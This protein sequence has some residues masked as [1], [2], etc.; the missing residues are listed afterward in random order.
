MFSKHFPYFFI[1]SWNGVYN[2]VKVLIDVLNDGSEIYIIP[3][4]QI[5]Q[6]FIC[7][8]FGQFL[9]FFPSMSVAPIILIVCALGTFS[10]YLPLSSISLSS[11]KAFFIHICAPI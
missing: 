9:V 1:V 2:A 5:I 7:G 10:I 8:L 3:S 11:A 6:G 4:P